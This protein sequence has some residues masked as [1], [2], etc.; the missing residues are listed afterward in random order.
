[1]ALETEATENVSTQTT[2][3]ILQLVS[4][5]LGNEEFGIDILAVQ[6]I[7]R[8]IEITRVPNSPN[9]VEGVINLR[10]KVLPVVNL[11]KRLGLPV[12]EYDKS[13][14]IVVVDLERKTVGFIVD[15]VS[16]VL[17]ISSVVTEPPPQMVGRVDS[18][19]ITAVGKLE[20]RLVILLDLN[21]ILTNKEIAALS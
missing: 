15:S 17:R 13:T 16:E 14:R 7:I 9:F 1:M 6:E 2:E 18:E 3:E 4:F 21:R 19:Y 10:G 20:D 5:K 8:M 11:R 12:K